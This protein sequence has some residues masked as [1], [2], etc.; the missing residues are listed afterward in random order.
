MENRRCEWRYLR[1]ETLE[2][3]RPIE[4]RH[5]VLEGFTYYD[6]SPGVLF[7]LYRGDDKLMRTSLIKQ[8]VAQTNE[9][10]TFQTQNTKYKLTWLPAPDKVSSPV[11]GN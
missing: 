5:K 1:L 10:I 3:N 9:S 4:D 7:V 2:S 11:A 6:P 8:V